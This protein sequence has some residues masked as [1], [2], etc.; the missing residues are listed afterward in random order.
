MKKILSCLFLLVTTMGFAKNLVVDNQTPYPIREQ[1]S[2]IAVQWAATAKEVD[3]Y[4][5]AIISGSQMNPNSFQMLAQTGVI[6][7]K[8][9]NDAEY[10]RILVWTQD[11]LEPN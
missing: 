10:F 5:K 3:T 1:K 2:K 8:I 7:L 6:H 9:P 11:G 4:N